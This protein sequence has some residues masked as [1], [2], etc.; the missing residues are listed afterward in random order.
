MTNQHTRPLKPAATPPL[1]LSYSECVDKLRSAML[2]QIGNAPETIQVSGKLERFDTVKRGDKCG[3]YVAHVTRWGMVARFGD[4]REGYPHKWSSFEEN[5]LSRADL[6][7]FRQLQQRQ[8]QE[9][10]AEREKLAESARNQ[11]VSVWGKAQP[12]SHAHPYLVRKQVQAHGIRQAGN[13]LLIPLTDLSG[14]L[15]NLQTITPDGTKRF[16]FGG[17]KRGLCF[18]LGGKLAKSEMVYLCEGYATGASLYEAYHLPVLV[19]F[20]AGNLLPVAQSFRRQFIDLPLTVCADN[21]RKGAVNTGLTKAREVCA[22]VAGT[23]II[24]P[25]FPD[26][27]PL[28]LSDFNDAVNYYRSMEAT[29]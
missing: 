26:N 8:D 11:A 4:W 24:I 21:D 7:E 22:K 10:K 17:R 29:Q 1:C 25:E 9:R 6:A 12:A 14:Y 3:W 20:D 16:L 2:G 19:A 23:Q 27:A 5:S 18:L 28:E 13:K 15:H